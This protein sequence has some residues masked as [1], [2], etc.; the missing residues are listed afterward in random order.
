MS[1]VSTGGEREPAGSRGRRWVVV[2]VI[3]S[4]ASVAWWWIGHRPVLDPGEL[5]G[6]R[7][8]AAQALRDAETSSCPR[9]PLR[10]VSRP[11]SGRDALRAIFDRTGDHARCWEVLLAEDRGALL[12]M[13]QAGSTQEGFDELAPDPE[14]LAEGPE[15]PPMPEAWWS[16]S[17]GRAV[18]PT[19]LPIEERIAGACGETA[20]AVRD[21]LA[22]EDL[23]S[24]FG[25]GW[26][27]VDLLPVIRFGFVLVAIAREA[28]R[29]GDLAAGVQALLDGIR[30]GTDL[31][32][33]RSTWVGT[34]AGAA[35]AGTMLGQIEMALAQERA[36]DEATIRVLQREIEVLVRTT[37][38]PDGPLRDDPVSMAID[39][40][41][42]G[43]WE[44]PVE[45]PWEAS[46]AR[47]E[48]TISEAREASP[49]VVFGVAASI[50]TIRCGPELSRSACVAR[51]DE[52]IARAV[53]LPDQP[54]LWRVLLGPRMVRPALD[55]IARS[56]LLEA[57]APYV[58]RWEHV[59]LGTAATW[60][61][62]EH[63]ALAL[64]GRC[65]RADE[66]GRVAMPPGITSRL[67][68]SFEV[69]E[70]RI[71]H[72]PL[73][74]S[75]PSWLRSPEDREPPR[76]R[77]PVARAYCPMLVLRPR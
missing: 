6:A 7:A 35:V 52:E 45:L 26:M 34:M 48:E 19:A 15:D 38:T 28:L 36:W 64:G 43:G 46:E 2:A 32:R 59:A 11:G 56:R 41:R 55:D 3:A 65:P 39:A 37:P 9:E 49:V 75:A 21:A 44:P 30:L 68:G 20:Q 71:P 27:H 14:P 10:G 62:L 16:F 54:P 42:A 12:A 53:A 31:A 25:L 18:G 50:D 51:I 24:P 22:R 72:R 47:V 33:G 61:V 1:V 4:V 57:V 8:S 70:T 5:E 60:L 76:V 73:E 77:L 58:R 66:L 23:C 13:A 29:R 63:R 40:L 17:M 67:G 74:I 69:F